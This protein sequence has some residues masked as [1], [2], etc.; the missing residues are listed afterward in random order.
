MNILTIKKSTLATHVS[1]KDTKMVVQ[2]ADGRELSVPLEWFPR[3]RDAT[4]DQLKDWRFIGNG[5]GIHW[6]ELDE[7]I[8]V[9]ALL[10]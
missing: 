9:K 3:L 8:S 5:E 6:T 2:L 1:F 4:V 7:D 10:E